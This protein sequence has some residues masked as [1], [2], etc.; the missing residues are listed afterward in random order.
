MTVNPDTAKHTYEHDGKKYYFCA[1]NCREKFIAN[2][3]IYLNKMYLNKAATPSSGLVTL[4]GS[5]GLSH[6]TK[7]SANQ[8]HATGKQGSPAYVCPMCPEVR[9]S[10]P[11]ACPS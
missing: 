5:T 3:T 11:G 8:A 2:P 7:E 1:A 10:K 4:A 6:P 9:E